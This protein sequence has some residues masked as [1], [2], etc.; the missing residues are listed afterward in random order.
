MDNYW[1]KFVVFGWYVFIG[2][3]F[4]LYEKITLPLCPF[5]RRQ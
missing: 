4:S 1:F 3:D 5:K 2:K